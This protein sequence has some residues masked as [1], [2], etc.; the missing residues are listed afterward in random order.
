[1]PPLSKYSMGRPIS[2]S[3]RDLRLVNYNKTPKNTQNHY[4]PTNYILKTRLVVT[5]CSPVI[6]TPEISDGH[7][8]IGLCTRF[9][10]QLNVLEKQSFSI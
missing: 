9:P 6:S 4:N 3:L 2:P 10:D 5:R 8:A 7:S 1:M